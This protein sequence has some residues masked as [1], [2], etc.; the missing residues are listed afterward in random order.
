MSGGKMGLMYEKK[1]KYS[2]GKMNRGKKLQADKRRTLLSDF[3]DFTGLMDEDNYDDEDETGMMGKSEKTKGKS[4]KATDIYKNGKGKKGRY[5]PDE[6]DSEVYSDDEYEDSYDEDYGKGYHNSTKSGKG[7]G[8]TS[9]SSKAPK[10]NK[11]S[12]SSKSRTDP[13]CLPPK[14]ESKTAKSAKSM[15]M[16]I[17]SGKGKGMKKSYSSKSAKSMG[18]SLKKSSKMPGKGG[19]GSGKGSI[20]D[21]GKGSSKGSTT[22]YSSGKG[23]SKGTYSPTITPKPVEE[24]P[25]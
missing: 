4:E 23:S 19:K 8:G 15:S 17:S 6:D 14:K 7:K 22:S 25:A 9:Y 24:P 16:S 2:D 21:S 20:M 3:F 11:S 5:Y 1:S 13:L 10:S 18:M 12:K